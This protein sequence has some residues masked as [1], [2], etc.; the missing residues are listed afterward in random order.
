LSLFTNVFSSLRG[1]KSRPWMAPPRQGLVPPR[2]ASTRLARIAL[3]RAVES[4]V[5]ADSPGLAAIDG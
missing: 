5:A 4:N 2:R 1:K 3:A